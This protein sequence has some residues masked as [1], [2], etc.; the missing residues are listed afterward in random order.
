MWTTVS[1][2][3]L[4]SAASLVVHGIGILSAA[5]AVM[6]V[7]SSR[8]AIAW[9]IG[10]VSLPWVAVPLYWTFGKNKFQ[11][12][13]EALREAYSENQATIHEAYS[14]ILDFKASLPPEFGSLE[15]LADTFTSLPFTTNNGIDLLIDGE[16]TFGEMLKAIAQAQDYILL[17]TY[18]IHDD[19]ISTTFKNALIDRAKQGVRVYLIYDG[20]GSHKLPHRYVEDLEKHG[21]TVKVFRSSKGLSR[22]FQIN[23]RNHRKILVVDGHTAFVGGFNIGDEY[24][25]KDPKLGDWRDTHLKI[26]GTTVQCLQRVFLGDWYWAAKDIPDVSWQ[27]RKEENCDQT[28]FILATGPADPLEACA[29]FFLNLIN[30]AKE[31]L[32]IASPY[33]VPGDSVLNAL[34]LAVL[35]G[36]DVR[37]I[38]PNQ[39]DHLMV[40]FCSFS[41]YEELKQVGIQVYRYQPGFMHQKVI[42]CDRN[43]AGVGTVNLDNRSFFLNF[44]VMAFV[45]DRN[46]ES[47]DR[48]TDFVNSVE[49]M[50]QKDFESSCLV[51]FAKYSEKPF[52]FKLAARISRLMSP[53]L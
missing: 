34:K 30:G 23:F 47:I 22:R 3:S 51:D 12:Y 25:G 44:E 6:K 41:Y 21:I 15:I 37:I 31:R 42:L 36:V 10:L 5:H 1:L 28:A 8:G 49:A 27:T 4:Y 38:L 50:L 45:V 35:R 24:L 52:W 13:S 9:G 39:P 29:L 18:I 48:T 32:W 43:I 53:I 20:I 2:L 33:F 11:G 19:E 16:Q 17:Q 14:E 46:T 26:Q 7:R 40:Y